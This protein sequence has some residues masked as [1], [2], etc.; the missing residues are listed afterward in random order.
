MKRSLLAG[1][2]FP[3]TGLWELAILYR[4]K[5]SRFTVQGCLFRF[6]FRDSFYNLGHKKIPLLIFRGV[7]KYQIS[8]EMFL[9]FVFTKCVG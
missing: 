7:G 2:W 5:G 9:F 4:F 6:E 8:I 1:Q 3:A